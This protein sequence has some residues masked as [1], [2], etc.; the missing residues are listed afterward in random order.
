[1][2][3]ELKQLLQDRADEKA[4]TQSKSMHRWR[5]FDLKN[6]TQDFEKIDRLYLFMSTQLA[7]AAGAEVDYR[8]PPRRL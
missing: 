5:Q 2:T 3:S 4:A 6:T 7:A 8:T 1:M